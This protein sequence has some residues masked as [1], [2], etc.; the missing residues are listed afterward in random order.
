[1]KYE[2]VQG[3]RAA[4]RLRLEQASGERAIF[5]RAPRFAYIIRGIVLEK[6][7]TVATEPDADLDLCRQLEEEGILKAVEDPAEEEPAA[8]E[9]EPE[10]APDP[11]VETLMAE[12]EESSGEEDTSNQEAVTSS[13]EVEAE[14]ENMEDQSAGYDDMVERIG[15]VTP[16]ISF[17]LDRHRPESIC[18]LVYTIYSRGKL[19][20]KATGGCFSASGELVERLKAGSFI[21]A[22][23]AVKAVTDEGGLKGISFGD[24]KVSFDGFP[25]TESRED[26]QAWTKLCEAVNRAAI[27][28]HTIHARQSEEPNEKFAFRTWLTRLGMNGPDLKVERT[29][30]YRNLSGHTAFRTQE[31]AEKWKARQAAKRQELREA[32][33]KSMEG[34]GAEE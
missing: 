11:D 30:L 9:A 24:G 23:D 22:E 29:I 16:V 27:K 15:S 1:M 25:E 3:D 19:L 2:I 12:E 17:P 14:T 20:S 32:K 6:D 28:Q 8:A 18:N 4:V 21:T 13:Q 7:G 31:D 10:E 34:N 5:T 33:E 26:V